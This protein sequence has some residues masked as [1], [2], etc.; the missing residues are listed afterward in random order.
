MGEVAG[1]VLDLVLS[2][3]ADARMAWEGRRYR[4]G[5]APGGDLVLRI[6]VVALPALFVLLLLGIW[7]GLRAIRG[8]P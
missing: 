4:R 1:G 5:E 3:L 6:A 7:Y 8:N 2:A